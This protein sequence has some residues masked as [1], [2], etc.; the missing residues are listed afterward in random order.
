MATKPTQEKPATNKPVGRSV[1]DF[2]AQY[3]KSYIVPLKVKA[4]L[5]KLGDGWLRELDFA[6]LA[7]V[8]PNDLAAYRAQFE[9]HVVALIGS[10]RGRR[11]WAGTKALA[12]KLRGMLS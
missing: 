1:E 6:K 5:E 2:R 7:G 9:D 4:A 10:E 8:T 3:D 12:N 11:A